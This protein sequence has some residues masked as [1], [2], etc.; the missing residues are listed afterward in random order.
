MEHLSYWLNTA[1]RQLGR[2]ISGPQLGDLIRLRA[3]IRKRAGHWNVLSQFS[4]PPGIRF[5]RT[6]SKSSTWLRA[7]AAAIHPQGWMD[8]LVD[9]SELFATTKAAGR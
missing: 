1:L 7:R 5:L 6:G 8:A 9:V 3:V 2:T 4:Q